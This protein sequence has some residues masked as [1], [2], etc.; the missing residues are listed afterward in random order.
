M[1]VSHELRSLANSLGLAWWAKVKTDQSNATY[2][3]G[4]FLT[5]RSLKIN[6]SGFLDD[7]SSE[8]H[9]SIDY[10][11]SRCRCIEPLTF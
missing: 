10:S 3:F 6:I 8:G 4:P 7:L 5:K 9:E 11:L 1:H 2:C